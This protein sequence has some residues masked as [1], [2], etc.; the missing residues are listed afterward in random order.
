VDTKNDI[1]QE[2][3][4]LITNQDS[5]SMMLDHCQEQHDTN[6][7]LNYIENIDNNL[8]EDAPM[9]NQAEANL[10]DNMTNPSTAPESAQFFDSAN[11]FPA[12][13]SY[14]TIDIS[15]IELSQEANQPDTTY[16]IPIESISVEE[17]RATDQSKPVIGEPNTSLAGQQY[18][19]L[20]QST[21]TS[22][23]GS[24][25]TASTNYQF[26]NAAYAD[27]G[28]DPIVM[29]T[30]NLY[31]FLSNSNPGTPDVDTSSFNSSTA[32]SCTS[33]DE[34]TNMN[35]SIPTPRYTQDMKKLTKTM[36][37]PRRNTQGPK[38]QRLETLPAEN[39]KNVVRCRKYRA[40]KKAQMKEEEDELNSL[41][42]KN[43]ELKKKEKRLKM[44]VTK[45]Q[46]SYLTMIQQGK[47]KFH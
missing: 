1:P 2:L 27:I 26:S 19:M 31:D 15:A 46:S 24:N 29:T 6:F 12:E 5:D 14:Y 18:N 40:S 44:M 33:E 17:D 21:N 13:P 28:Q 34:N 10:F 30:S 7:I 43:K 20:V 9:I 25:S 47:I 41:E 45:M 35:T 32:S 16:Q 36:K 22:L 4:D 8:I 38:Q 37:T 42:A 3:W 11:I 23:S 39:Q